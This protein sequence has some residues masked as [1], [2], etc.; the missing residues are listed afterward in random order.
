MDKILEGMYLIQAGCET[1]NNFTECGQCPFFKV[2]KHLQTTGKEK[3]NDKTALIP[4]FWF[5][6]D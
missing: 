2:C 6:W 5:D 1:V 3:Y 4:D